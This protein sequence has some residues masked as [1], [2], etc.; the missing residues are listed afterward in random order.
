MISKK[1]LYSSIKKVFLDLK[2]V[3]HFIFWDL[4]SRKLHLKSL[5]NAYNTHILSKCTLSFDSSFDSSFVLKEPE[6]FL[7]LVDIMDEQIKL[8][9]NISYGDNFIKMKDSSFESEYV[10]ADINYIP[11]Y[12]LEKKKMEPEEPISYDVQ[13][14]L[15][16]EFKE[17]FLK[18]KKANKSS[19]VFI[20]TKD[21][22][23]YFQLGE[24]NNFT[25]KIKFSIEMPGMFDM[26][27]LS[28]SADII[29]SVIERNKNA[30]GKMFVDP[31][32]LMKL[33]FREDI[34]GSVIETNYFLVAQ[35]NI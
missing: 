29:Q 11:E 16:G 1:L 28:F 3:E 15:D 12:I 14:Q 30:N 23:T 20:S 4:E 17:K 25:N 2:D 7:K 33:N 32:G 8:D 9:I 5:D 21:R 22:T 18:A 24:N 31:E 13:I 27:T 10:I 26:G 34:D 6:Q 35:D 19:L